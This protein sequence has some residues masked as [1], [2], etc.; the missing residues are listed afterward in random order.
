MGKPKAKK[1]QQVVREALGKKL[2]RRAI[3]ACEELEAR[4]LAILTP[5]KPQ[6][7]S[8]LY[9]LSSDAYWGRY[10]EGVR[11]FEM[12]NS[13][14][15][16]VTTRWCYLVLNGLKADSFV[17]ELGVPSGLKR[18]HFVKRTVQ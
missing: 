11:L 3:K 2:S 13:L 10:Q 15:G 6:T 17:I 4:N 1:L 16:G 9:Q 5:Q 8:T 14:L 18:N 12:D 7:V